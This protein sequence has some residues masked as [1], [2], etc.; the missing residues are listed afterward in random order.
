MRKVKAVILGNEFADDHLPWKVACDEFKENIEYRVVDLTAPDWLDAIRAEPFDILLA[1]PGGF[2]AAYKQL[3]DERIYVLGNILR[4]QIYPSVEEIL[5]Y[6]NKRFLSFWLQANGVPHPPT[7]VF[8]DQEEA[9]RYIGE[10]WFPIVAKTNIGASGRGV[11][12]LKDAEEAENYVWRA[13]TPK[14]AAKRTGPNFSKG[15]WL[16][17]GFHY[18]LHPGDIG[19]KLAIYK[20][21]MSDRQVGFIILQEFIPHGFEWRVV[22]IGD[23]FFAHKKLKSGDKASG[24]L[25]KGYENPPLDL[26]DFVRKITDAHGFFSQAVDIF[27]S[28]KGYLVN[29][30]QCIFGQSDSFQMLV[31]GKTGRYFWDGKR[32][33]FE[34]GDFNRNESFNLRVQYAMEMVNTKNK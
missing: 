34:E 8:Y 6:E 29:E 31:D 23:S 11:I 22:R 15:G 21:L 7:W 9:M 10:A 12:L 30:M 27:E 13:F 28:N 32:W 25:L 26:L 3:F 17:R 5:I 19:K 4:Y 1:K 16:K 18:A 24:S 33:V 20:A 2:T 14:G